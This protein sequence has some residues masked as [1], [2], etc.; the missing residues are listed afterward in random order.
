MTQLKTIRE[1]MAVVG[2]DG[3]P[4]GTVDGVEVDRI[5]LTRTGNP[6]GH[7]GYHHYLAADLVA[8]V[9]GDTV[10]LNTTAA[11][12]MVYMDESEGADRS[13]NAVT[14][15]EEEETEAM[16]SYGEEDAG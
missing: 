3:G 13:V 8:G 4:V 10:R 16:A 1:H 7:E 15:R 11:S 9:E 6:A 14:R 5:K 12:A 2:S